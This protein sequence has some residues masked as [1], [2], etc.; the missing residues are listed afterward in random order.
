MVCRDLDIP[1]SVPQKESEET[2]QVNKNAL[3]HSNK[4]LTDASEPS[5]DVLLT[6]DSLSCQ[7]AIIRKGN[8]EKAELF[9]ITP[10]LT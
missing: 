6:E 9:Q 8:G 2:G 5:A 10:E 4:D 1:C 3:K 7:E